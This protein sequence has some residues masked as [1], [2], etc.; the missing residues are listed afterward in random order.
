MPFQEVES[1]AEASERASL[2]DVSAHLSGQQGAAGG[3]Q[4]VTD[5]GDFIPIF[6]EEEIK[7]RVEQQEEAKAAEARALLHPEYSTR[8]GEYQPPWL[9]HS[10]RLRSPLLRLHNEIV[11]FCRLLAP[12]EAEAKQRQ[13]A[14]DAV[15]GVVSEIWP[16]ATTE[17]FGSFL[18]GLYTPTSDIDVVIL[19]S[20]SSNV[21]D[22]LR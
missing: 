3:P 2:R 11:E 22:S 6:T 1:E 7:Q 19:N 12:T 16:G 14:L 4:A 17:L 9:R 20:R 5:V 10:S 15:A 13:E 21:G 18:T 8:Y